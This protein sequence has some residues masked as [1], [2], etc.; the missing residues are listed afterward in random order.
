[1]EKEILKN[2][3]KEL[4][5]KKNIIDENE[6]QIKKNENE[7]DILNSQNIEL[8]EQLNMNDRI[9]FLYEKLSDYKKIFLI[10]TL[11]GSVLG[12][13]FEIYNVIDKV[14]ILSAIGSFFSTVAISSLLG[15][16]PYVATKLNI[17]EKTDLS[18][19]EVSLKIE[20]LKESKYLNRE[21]FKSNLKEIEN[22][23]QKNVMIEN[24]LFNETVELLKDKDAFEEIISSII[25]NEPSKE[26]IEIITEDIAKTKIKK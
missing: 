16:I 7:N 6:K 8:T 13:G 12:L 9:V 10:V 14:N 5:E 17:K 3:K 15:S 18:L 1:M 19:E 11:I 2:K 22:L 4:I 25:E 21:K 26:L 23:K 20:D 24:K